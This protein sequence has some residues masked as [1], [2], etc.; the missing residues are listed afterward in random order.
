MDRDTTPPFIGGDDELVELEEPIEE[1][2]RP[3]EFDD[4]DRPRGDAE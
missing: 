4:E 2:K 1:E 3:V